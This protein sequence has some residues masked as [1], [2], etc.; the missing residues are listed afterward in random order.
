MIIAKQVPP[1]Y[2]ESPLFLC[3]CFPENIAVYGNRHY[4]EHC[5]EV[6]NNVWDALYHGELLEAWENIND[7]GN[8]YYYKWADALN[9]IVPPSDAR[10][11]YTRE[12]RKEKWPDIVQRFYYAGYNS[13]EEDTALCDAL[14]LMTGEKWETGTIRGCVQR[15]WQNIAYPVNQWSREALNAFEMEYFNTGTEWVV[16]YEDTP[17][18][19]YCYSYDDEQIKTEI[20]EAVGVDAA[21]ITLYAFDGWSHSAIYVEV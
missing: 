17:I 14:E 19:V 18:R 1:E 2:Q 16:N 13:Y 15:E 5:P 12:E 10:G 6:F 7:N 3:D 9:D 21:E 11:P 8:G 4:N 20:A